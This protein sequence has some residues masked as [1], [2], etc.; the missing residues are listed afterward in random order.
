MTLTFF[1]MSTGHLFYR[2]SLILCLSFFLL[3]ISGHCIFSKNITEM[4]FFHE[5]HYRRH[6]VSV[7]PITGDVA[8]VKVACLGFPHRNVCVSPLVINEGIL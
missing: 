4:P 8:L 3:S 2:V 1:K 5:D 7:Y 6:A